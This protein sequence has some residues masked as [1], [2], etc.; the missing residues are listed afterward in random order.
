MS[1]CTK[2]RCDYPD[3]W[4]KR[5][6]KNYSNAEPYSETIVVF[7]KNNNHRKDDHNNM[8]QEDIL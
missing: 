4:E 2:T 3:Q 8:L 7:P 1:K 6:K 5:R